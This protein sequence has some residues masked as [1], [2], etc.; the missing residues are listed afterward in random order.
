MFTQ[1]ERPGIEYVLDKNK[2]TNQFKIN[3]AEIRLMIPSL[4]QRVTELDSKNKTIASLNKRMQ[5][6]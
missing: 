3:L 6:L 5:D 1:G 2:N 4:N